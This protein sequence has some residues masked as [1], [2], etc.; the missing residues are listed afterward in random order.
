MTKTISGWIFLVAGSA[1]MVAAAVGLSA[2]GAGAQAFPTR[3]IE[4][5][6]GYAPGG[7]SDAIARVLGKKLEE[8]F[9]QPVTVVNKPGASGVVAAALV[10]KARGDG[11]TIHVISSAAVTVVPHIEKVEY[12]P[13]T[14]FTYLA[15][16]VRQ[17]PAVIVRAEAPWKTAQEFLEYAKSN[18]RKVKYGSYGEFGGAHIA[19]EGIGRERGLEWVHVPFKGDGPTVTALL[20]GHID[21]A[22]TAAGHV[23]HVRAGK[24]RMLLM[25]QNRR[26]QVFPDVPSLRDLGLKFDAK[27]SSDVITGIVAPKG[28]PREIARKYE[29]AL[30]RAARSPEFVKVT[31]TL[32]LERAFVRGAEFQKE[33]EEGHAYV[34]TTLKSVGLMK[35]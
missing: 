22:T 6:V 3:P 7:A 10:S 20:G 26:S 23:P 17:A 13:L 35:K 9:G 12:N 24:F 32:A 15:L 27:G 25:L 34:V 33:V 19:M 1:A 5:V 31:E 8:E 16:V 2:S 30:E 28:L 29:E 21:A 4:F 18:P 11:H 14:D